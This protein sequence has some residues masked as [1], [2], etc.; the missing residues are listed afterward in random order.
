MTTSGI[1]NATYVSS[2]TNTTVPA[3]STDLMA[4]VELLLVQDYDQQ[5]KDMANSIKINNRL[6][7]SY[8]EHKIAVNNLLNKEQ[9]DGKVELTAE[10]YN[11]LNN[12]PDYRWDTSLNEGAG[13]VADYSTSSE[14]IASISNTNYIDVDYN[15]GEVV[16]ANESAEFHGDPHFNDADSAAVGM[17]HTDWD[18]QGKAGE[19]YLYLQDSNLSM[20]ATHEAYGDGGATVVGSVN[21]TL[22]GPNGDSE[23]IFDAEGLPTLNGETM[24]TGVTYETADGG[25]ATYSGDKL[26]VTTAEGYTITLFDQGSHFNG[27]VT[28]SGKGVLSDGIA[29]T[30]VLGA[31]FDADTNIDSGTDN[32]QFNVTGQTGA[33]AGDARQ[34]YKVEVDR[35]KSE[36][37][38][39]QMKLDG[40]NSETELSQ[41]ELSTLTSQRKLAFETLS[42]MLSKVYEGAS[43]VVRNIK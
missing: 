30:G 37:E 25:S 5:M 42:T 1:S 36:I 27:Q 21:I 18:F 26:T 24:T 3:S 4:Y 31:Q 9:D 15:G 35:I 10:E 33:T 43:T 8:R 19:T 12:Q 22:N 6:K 17:D 16:A 23:I 41:T 20:T 32:E 11:L 13:G 39:L 38:R 40:L 14:E 7:Q 2:L 34:T 29:P 28:T